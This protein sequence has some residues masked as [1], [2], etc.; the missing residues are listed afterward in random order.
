MMVIISIMDQ[1]R[2]KNK[3]VIS[4]SGVDF[5]FPRWMECT[6][7]RVPCYKKSCAICGKMNQRT[8]EPIEHDEYVHD[9][10]VEFEDITHSL[11]HALTMIKRD[12]ARLGIDI[13][14]IDIIKEPPRPSA[15]PLYKKVNSWNKGVLELYNIAHEDGALWVFTEAAADFFWYADLISAK[16]Y[17]QLCNKWHLQHNDQYGDIDYAYTH[18]VLNECLVILK[19]SLH[20][21][22]QLP[23]GHKGELVSMYASL[24]KLES[25]IQAI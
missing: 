9:V 23:S 6:W 5:K 2:I 14:N 3:K 22:T 25:L 15:F 18:Y 20:A 16:T 19:R 13:S 21:L 12:A 10:G 11:R 7:R 24:L 4:L 8:K 17:R 1:L